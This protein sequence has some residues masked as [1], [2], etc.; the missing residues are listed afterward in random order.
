M[1][2]II[3]LYSQFNE[4]KLDDTINISY[5]EEVK[6]DID[7]LKW[8]QELDRV[9]PKLKPVQTGSSKEWRTHYEQMQQHSA[10]IK[11]LSNYTDNVMKKLSV[12]LERQLDQVQ[13][14]ER[15][16]TV[17]FQNIVNQYSEINK[18]KEDKMTEVSQLQELIDTVKSDYDIIKSKIRELKDM[19]GTGKTVGDTGP[20]IRMKNALKALKNEVNGLNAQIGVVSHA[21]TQ[22]YSDTLDSYDDDYNVSIE[23]D[24]TIDFRDSES[25]S[26]DDYPYS[27]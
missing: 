12:E 26:D 25:S 16:L 17:Q 7:P 1:S 4:S 13:Q 15:T 24:E 23:E 2:I 3:L 8:K 19:T 9:A 18:Q 10:D 21:I 14:R 27:R 22:T 11:V 6:S 5:F 20:V